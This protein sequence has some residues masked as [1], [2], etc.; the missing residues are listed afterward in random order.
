M[1][2]LLSRIYDNARP[3]YSQGTHF[4]AGLRR[5]FAL[6]ENKSLRS[7]SFGF[8]PRLVLVSSLGE[9]NSLLRAAPVWFIPVLCEV[10]LDDVPG[11]IHAEMLFYELAAPAAH[12][13]KLCIVPVQVEDRIREVL[14]SVANCNDAFNS[15]YALS[16][17][18]RGDNRASVVKG[19][20]DLALHARTIAEGNNDEPACGVQFCKFRF[21]DESFSCACS[22]FE[23]VRIRFERIPVEQVFPDGRKSV[24]Y[25]V[26]AVFCYFFTNVSI[27]Q[28]CFFVCS[29]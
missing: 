18:V 20:H 15:F 5:I 2:R 27:L 29:S 12:F 25:E 7:A 23:N 13:H 3:R 6:A 8:F 4:C 26:P 24:V 16:P 28:A 11:C 1:T 9:R 19:F 17:D 10:I 22:Y 14:C 21:A